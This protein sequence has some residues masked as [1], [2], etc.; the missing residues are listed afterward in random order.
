[1][2]YRHLLLPTLLL[3]TIG[4]GSG[5][6]SG[7]SPSP[8]PTP[9]PSDSPS[10]S[11]FVR[12]TSPTDTVV[13]ENARVEIFTAATGMLTGIFALTDSRGFYQ[14]SG[15]SGRV[16]L[17]ASKEGYEGQSKI[18]QLASGQRTLDFNLLPLARRPPRE[19]LIVGQTYTGTISR[20]DP[21]CTGMYFTLY[22]KRYAF[23]VSNTASFRAYLKWANKFDLDLE[24]WR[25][26]RLVTASL[27]CQSCGIGTAEETFTQTIPPGEYE[28]R[29]TWYYFFDGT[30]ITPYELNVTPA[31]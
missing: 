23:T 16:D 25:D 11:G 30:E 24:L 31:G 2:A 29:V 1:M 19:T 9:A 13:V 21:M 7:P 20:M 10:L 15:L 6:P 3:I 8:S 17:R 12:E 27:T 22:C 14:F 18:A 28:L 5:S 26:D 4:C